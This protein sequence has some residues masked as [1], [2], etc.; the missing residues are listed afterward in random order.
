[1]G[2]RK[3]PSTAHRLAHGDIWLTTEDSLMALIELGSD[4]PLDCC[5]LVACLDRT[6]PPA[7]FKGLMRDLGWVG[8]SLITLEHWAKACDV[9]S[10]RW[11]FLGMEI[12]G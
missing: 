11:V 5:R 1:M 6:T 3:A 12:Q 2:E 7:E 9:T 8:F 10:D 4:S